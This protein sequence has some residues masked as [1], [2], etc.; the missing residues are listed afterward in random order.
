MI[1]LDNAATSWPKPPEVLKAISD[2]MERAGGNP[3]RSGHSLSVASARVVY[4]C[5]EKAAEFFNVPDPLRVIFTANATQAINLALRGIL[6]PGDH[7]VTT[8]ME[9]NAV[10][11]PLRFLEK[12]GVILHIA[13]C[14]TDGTLDTGE[15]SQLIT[16]HTRLVV[17]T[18]A[19][20]VSGTILPTAEVTAKA[21]ELGVPVLVDASQSAGAIPVDVMGSGIDLLAFTGHKE[22]LG[23]TG[24][25]GLVINPGFDISSIEPLVF[26]GTGS[27]S[28]SE[29]QPEDLPDKFESGTANLM[30][31]TGLSA[32][33]D[34]INDRGLDSIREHTRLLVKA[35]IEG[36][37]VIPG[38]KS[39]GTRN[40]E[41][42]VAIVSFTIFGKR[43]SDIGFKLDEEF[44]ILSRVG[45]HC[46][47][48]A[49]KTLGSFPEGTVR[50]SPGVFTS[51]D[52]ID[53]TLKAIKEVA[54][55]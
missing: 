16:S 10:M 45:L 54:R 21:H 48:A 37:S 55:S 43:V 6:K 50:L 36:L 22:L 39:Y 19:S 38:V 13:Q 42:S 41:S 30:G 1:Y 24:T 25:G 15:L 2:V 9:H 12:Q 14:A 26:G 3:G 34:W 29:E 32:G 35:L 40:A 47:P 53:K 7:V 46:A 52:D 11:R 31:I 49:H 23:P 27:R 44:G 20:N 33:L 51:M 17:M 5:R 8:S 4:D 18:Q 28:E